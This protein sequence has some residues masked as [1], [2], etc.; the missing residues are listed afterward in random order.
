M[1]ISPTFLYTVVQYNV[2]FYPVITPLIGA[3]GWHERHGMVLESIMHV[4]HGNLNQSGVA[5]PPSAEIRIINVSD[6]DCALGQTSHGMI[7]W[8]CCVLV[9]ACVCHLVLSSVIARRMNS[10][11]STIPTLRRSRSRMT[12]LTRTT[13]LDRSGKRP[14]RCVMTWSHAQHQQAKLRERVMGMGGGTYRFVRFLAR[15]S[16][17]F[18]LCFS[19]AAKIR[20]AVPL[21]NVIFVVFF[22]RTKW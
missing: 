7:R 20:S 3:H 11:N 21:L 18:S 22:F 19:L 6:Y 14:M 17:S 4:L 12:I 13:T 1:T 5:P 16:L 10:Q 8:R 2:R 15:S 9:D